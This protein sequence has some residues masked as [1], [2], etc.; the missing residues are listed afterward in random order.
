MQAL[1]VLYVH[2]LYFSS[3]VVHCVNALCP[4]ALG[5][6]GCKICKEF[7][8][9]LSNIKVVFKGGEQNGQGRNNIFPSSHA[10]SLRA[11]VLQHQ[12]N[13]GV[14]FPQ[15]DA[16]PA[17]PAAAVWVKLQQGSTFIVPVLDG[18]SPTSD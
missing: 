17:K 3:Q 16:L 5:R 14:G 13:T 18:E 7:L 4:Q 12:G 11:A 1:Y 10:G 2:I 15:R 6:M 9:C 8:G